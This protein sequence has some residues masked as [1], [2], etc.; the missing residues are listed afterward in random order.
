MLPESLKNAFDLY[1]R[2]TNAI[3]TWLANTTDK[4]GHPVHT[5]DKVSRGRL[6]GKARKEAKA[7]AA[8][9]G[10]ATS[11]DKKQAYL[12]HLRDFVPLATF[13]ASV[14]PQIQVP[15]FMA[16]TIDRVIEVRRTVTRIMGTNDKNADE[17]S[18]ASHLHFVGVLEQVR[19]ILRQQMPN[20]KLEFSSLRLSPTDDRINPSASP[21]GGEDETSTSRN[22]FD[23]LNLYDIADQVPDTADA[24]SPS[25]ILFEYE[26]EPQDTYHDACLAFLSLLQEVLNQRKKVRELWYNYR[27]GNVYLGPAAVGVNEAIE[28]CRRTEENLAPVINKARSTVDFLLIVFKI[29]CEIDGQELKAPRRRRGPNYETYDTS[30]ILMWNTC[31][32][33]KEFLLDNSGGNVTIYQGSHGWYDETL[34]NA[35]STNKQKY[36]QDA[37]AL[38][39]VLSDIR[40]LDMVSDKSAT[41]DEFTRGIR[42]LLKD[43]KLTLWQCFAAQIYLD[44]LQELQCNPDLAWSEMAG[45]GDVIKSS[46]GD[47][48]E[49]PGDVRLVDN[50]RDMEDSLKKLKS[51]ASQWD[52]DPIARYMTE[53]GFGDKQIKFK[54]LRRHPLYCGVWVHEMRARFHEAGVNFASAFGYVHQTYQLYHALQQERLLGPFAHW[55]DLITLFEM[56]S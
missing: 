11:T 8:T 25:T 42:T 2:D 46:L 54:F 50:W 21:T 6:K 23:I 24:A 53:H 36:V 3:A 31:W 18:D 34:H 14:K 37:R 29:M 20:N 33:L 10:D 51:D 13:I 45:S 32:I 40:V 30:S 4:N 41:E 28:I 17:E 1:K 38:R 19:D 16:V 48:L 44:G 43:E 35:S 55:M 5:N 49:Q 15:P 39:E 12:L 26:P 9:N 7:A 22:P 56:V 27:V 52:T 47:A